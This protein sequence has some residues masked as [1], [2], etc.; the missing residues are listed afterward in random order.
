MGV[1]ERF[2]PSINYHYYS[3][4]K[5]H[6][7]FRGPAPHFQS[8]FI[9][10]WGSTELFGRYV[11]VT[12]SDFL[13]K[14]LETK[15]VNF[16][17][18]HASVDAFNWQ[19]VFET[20]A[21]KAALNV[22]QTLPSLHASNPFYKVHPLRNDRIILVSPRL[23]N[24]FPESLFQEIYF[25]GHLWEE[26]DSICLDRSA[27]V[28]DIIYAHVQKKF[29]EMVEAIAPERRI[30]LDIQHGGALPR[31]QREE[32]LIAYEVPHI[33]AQM[34]QMGMV[35]QEFE[36]EKACR[37]LSAAAHF[38]LA[39]VLFRRFGQVDFQELAA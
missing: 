33:V 14:K 25:I 38:D 37:N 35:F 9:A 15:V 24:L 22:I 6:A 13:E 29:D 5:M 21:S 34:G 18:Q 36:R 1:S 7:R 12:A 26:L 17:I 39:E 27:I 11:P 32:E 28:R 30:I 16:S 23:K 3:L 4:P 8:P 31:V 10:V 2:L 20:W 19:G